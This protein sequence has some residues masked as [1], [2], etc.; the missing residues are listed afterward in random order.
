MLKANGFTDIEKYAVF[1]NHKYPLI[2]ISLNKL[3]ECKDEIPV[4]GAV[5]IKAEKR[6]M[7]IN[8]IG[9]SV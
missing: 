8:C 5:I 1:P 2:I 3:D 6:F 7:N 9:V 4:A